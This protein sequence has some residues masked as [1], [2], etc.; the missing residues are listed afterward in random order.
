[1]RSIVY[2]FLVIGLN[3]AGLASQTP[4]S[5]DTTSYRSAQKMFDNL[6]FEAIKQRGIE[7]HNLAI[8]AI[9]QAQELPQLTAEQQTALA[10]ERGKNNLALGQYHQAEEAFLFATKSQDYKRAAQEGLYSVYH[11]QGD[12]GRAL[13]VVKKLARGDAEYLIDVVKIHI[14][15]RDF[16][17]AIQLLDSLDH[18]WG[19]SPV[20]KVLRQEVYQ[21]T[22]DAEQSLALLQKEA[23]GEVPSEQHYLNKVY[24]LSQKNMVAEA[25]KTA[26]EWEKNYPNSGQANLA[27]YKFYRDQQRHDKALESMNVVLHDP[28]VKD[29]SVHQVVK[30][31]L[32]FIHAQP[33]YEWTLNRYLTEFTK[34]QD[35]EIYQLLGQY[36]AVKGGGTQ[37]IEFLQ[38]AQKIDP[39][40]HNIYMQLAALNYQQHQYDQGIEYAEQGLNLFPAQSVFYLLMAKG[41]RAKGANKQALVYLEMG[42][43]YVLDFEQ[44][45]RLI[46]QEGAAIYQ[47]LGQSDQAASWR[48]LGQINTDE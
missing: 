14:Q 28:I 6:F 23:K 5:V 48:K 7:N 24:A 11:E 15:Q 12:F 20:R 21:N 27:L 35:A 13:P 40:N 8:K 16:M 1:M 17:L 31:Y 46:Y 29:V 22:N 26:L 43:D 19:E 25:F 32:A 38:R 44:E 4:T 34:R 33:Q 10:F 2:I 47:E 37:A 9:D 45:G 18:K 3:S 42:L 41:Y 39:N 30:D 36:F